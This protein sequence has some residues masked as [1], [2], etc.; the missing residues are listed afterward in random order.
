M[1]LGNY[2]NE[3]QKL[4]IEK[5]IRIGDRISIRKSGQI[6]DGLLMPKS[7]GDKNTLVIKLSNGY[8]TGIDFDKNAIIE[9]KEGEKQIGKKIKIEKLKPDPNKPNIS[10]LSTGGT[11]ASKVDY[12]TGGVTPLETPEELIYSVPEL[13]K[14]ANIKFRQVF[15]MF[16]EDMEPYHW[17]ELAKKIYEEIQ[18]TKPDGIIIAHGTDTLHYTSIALSFMLQDS[19]IPILLVGSQR[20]TDRG[21]SDAAMNLVCAAQFIAKS[22]FSGISICMHASSSDNYCNIND[23]IRVRKMHSSRR[24]AF[25]S[26]DVMPYAKVEPDGTIEY[27]RSDYKKRDKK[28]K[29]V[30]IDRFEKRVTLIKLY[31]GFDY[32]ILENLEKLG[33]RGIVL[34]GTGL[35]HAPINVK[36]DYTKDHAKLLET[37]QNLTKK[38]ILII[39]TSQTPYGVVNLNVYSTGRLLL[40]AGVIPLPMTSEAAFM[41]LGWVL[42][43]TKDSEEAKKMMLKDQVGEFTKRIDPRAFEEM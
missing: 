20:S 19:P 25:R 2:S 31:P 37:I 39:M 26:I 27:F 3:I 16:S 40:D 29:P 23:S 10:I 41:K 12:K 15:Q 4:L 14:I 38:G 18:E 9:K 5:G 32:R 36:D 7:S 28:R 42:G 35:G 34:E 21:S 17:M 33:F 1:D 43:H 6:Y 8:N 24:D 30:L 13:G 11:I 22:D